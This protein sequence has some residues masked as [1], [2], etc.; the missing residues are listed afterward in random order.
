MVSDVKKIATA[1]NTYFANIGKK[2]ATNIND[3]HNTFED[4]QQYLDTPAETR[5]KFNWITEN[6]TIKSI[7]IRK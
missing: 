4:F 1:F 7:D 2:I 6:M 5:L 3:N